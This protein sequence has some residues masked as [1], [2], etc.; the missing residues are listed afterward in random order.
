MK[1]IVVNKNL[2]SSYIMA[3]L[4][5]SWNVWILDIFLFKDHGN[6]TNTI[7]CYMQLNL[8]DIDRSEVL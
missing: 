6:A 3:L 1:S 2:G 4:E 7:H 8:I 5:I